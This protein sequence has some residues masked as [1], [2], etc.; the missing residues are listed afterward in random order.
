MNLGKIEPLLDSKK[1]R[2][3]KKNRHF[4]S[5]GSR[6]TYLKIS[7][8]LEKIT[9]CVG[10]RSR[11]NTKKIALIRILPFCSLT[12]TQIYSQYPAFGMALACGL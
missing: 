1:N 12:I 8:V 9:T 10:N 7:W 2:N 5:G 6:L 4:G 11:I 3:H